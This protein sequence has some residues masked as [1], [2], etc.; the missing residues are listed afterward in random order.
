[1]ANVYLLATHSSILAW[2]ILWTIHRVKKRRTRLND[3]HFHFTF[4]HSNNMWPEHTW[5]EISKR[6]IAEV[7]CLWMRTFHRFFSIYVHIGSQAHILAIFSYR[8]YCSQPYCSCP[9]G[10][11]VFTSQDEWA[12]V[13]VPSYHWLRG[14]DLGL[15]YS[16]FP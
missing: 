16:S 6:K 15:G 7:P 8:S 3:S 1:M 5:E 14:V 4:N 2:R 13:T 9:C 12:F 10:H 11:P